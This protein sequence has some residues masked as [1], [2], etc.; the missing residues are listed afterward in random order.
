MELHLL[1]GHQTD[2]R[3]DIDDEYDNIDIE[4]KWE[5]LDDEY[6]NIDIDDDEWE[7]IDDEYDNIDIDDKWEDLDDEYDNIDIDD[8]WEDIDDEYDETDSDDVEN[9]DSGS[10]SAEEQM[11][12]S[13]CCST[14]HTH[15]LKQ[16][17]DHPTPGLPG[18]ESV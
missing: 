14:D 5:D 16:D 8:E 7:D 4:D 9:D 13:L 12:I 17:Q 18:P 1:F 6:D 2:E 11:T 15:T 3:E 10:E